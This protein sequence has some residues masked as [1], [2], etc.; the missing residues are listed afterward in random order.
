MQ[1]VREG[2]EFDAALA[3]GRV[4]ARQGRRPLAVPEAGRDPPRDRRAVHHL[5]RRGEQ[6]DAQASPRPRPQGLDLEPLLGNHAADRP[7]SSRRRPHRGVLPVARSTSKPGTSGTRTSSSSRTSCASSTMS[8]PT[9]SPARP[10]RW[11]A[12]SIQRR[13]RALGRPRRDGLPL[14]P[15]GPR[16]SRSKGRWRRA[17]TSRSSSTSARQVDQASMMLAKERGPCPD[18]ADMGVM[19]RFS[20]KMAIAPT[21]SISII[22]RRHQRVHR[23]DPGQHL[24][25][26]DPVGLLLDQEPVPGEDAQGEVEGQPAGLELDPRAGR[27]RPAP[28]LP[29]PGRKGRVQDQLRDRPALADRACGRPHA[30]HRPGA[31]A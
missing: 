20:C 15:P 30:V 22:C 27:Q 9:T 1:A 29:D 17:G 26:Q 2:A 11:R 23:A 21:A 13:A 19:E 28:R 31:V 7:R 12:P 25:P 24:H 6:G 4:G 8:S 14:L 18:A 3:Q 5:H 10:T 16:T